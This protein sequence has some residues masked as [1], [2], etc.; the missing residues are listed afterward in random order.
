MFEKLLS[1]FKKD[2]GRQTPAAKKP[3]ASAAAKATEATAVAN[4][5]ADT[6]T[7]TEGVTQDNAAVEA[8]PPE[9]NSNGNGNGKPRVDV[10]DAS[11]SVA[12]MVTNIAEQLSASTEQLS[13]SRRYTNFAFTLLGVT[14][15]STGVYLTVMTLQLSSRLT[16]VDETLSMLTEQ[17]GDQDNS[18]AL[19][20]EMRGEVTTLLAGQV[21]LSEQTSGGG[22]D[23]SENTEQLR[24]LT[25]SLEALLQNQAATDARLANL[26]ELLK[27]MDG[28]G[29]QKVQK[30]LEDVE[31]KVADL[32][33]IEQARIARE[34]QRLRS[35]TAASD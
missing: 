12:D 15:L 28:T 29:N 7:Q 17:T 1:K 33:V 10:I 2:K 34:L 24:R 3:A 25:Q 16:Q 32:Y 20:E 30:L 9:E 22:T 19:I 6:A 27:Q 23:N 18:I 5:D 14:L 11:N 8:S 4:D 31:Q 13:K 21:Q 26:G 35:E